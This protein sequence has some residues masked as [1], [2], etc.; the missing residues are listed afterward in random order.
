[1]TVRLLML[2]TLIGI[3]FA[4]TDW[5][6]DLQEELQR[7]PTGSPPGVPDFAF[8]EVLFTV[9]GLDGTPRYRIR[10]PRMA[11]FPLNQSSLLLAPTIWFF[12]SDGPPVKMHARRARV[13]ADGERVWLPGEVHI[14]RPPHAERPHM[15]IDTRDVTVFPKP[16][17]AR[18]E[19]RVVA[20]S[21][22]QRLQ[23]VGMM[24]DLSAGT[25]NLKSR[26]RGTYVP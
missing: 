7:A 23:G 19:T 25:L 20:A 10:A 9:M 4:L 2:V 16:K 18:S 1:M 11:H 3:A 24:L 13:F 14:T 6:Q 12:R 26:V 15:T 8:H 17:K 21:G 22:E 5:L